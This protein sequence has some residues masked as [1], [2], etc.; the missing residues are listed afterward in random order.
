MYHSGGSQYFV[1][2]SKHILLVTQDHMQS[3]K[4]VAYLLLGSFWLVGETEPVESKGFLS[5]S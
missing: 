5:L 4:L 2:G 1:Q 3:F